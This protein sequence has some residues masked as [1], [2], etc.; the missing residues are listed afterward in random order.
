MENIQ[1]GNSSYE[2]LFEDSRKLEVAKNP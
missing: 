1:G 2:K